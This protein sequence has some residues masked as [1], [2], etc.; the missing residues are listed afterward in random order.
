MSDRNTFEQNPKFKKV[1]TT[2]KDLF[3]RYG[4]KRV[5]IEEICR[6]SG[7]SKMTFYKFF[8]NKL[9]LAKY[10][11]NSIFG[12]AIEE[13]QDI[14]D[15]ENS[16][17]DKLKLLIDLKRRGTDHIGA[18]FIAE[19]S[20]HPEPEIAVIYNKQRERSM[21]ITVIFFKQAQEK[22]ELRS[23]IKL[24]FIIYILNK[25][26]EMSTDDALTGMYTSPQ[27]IALEMTNFLFYGILER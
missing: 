3:Y 13:F 25:M 1:V 16:F 21:D 12:N 11:L 9:E 8:P 5:T 19:L 4:I 6:E 22:G 20:Q 15:S 24:E 26:I 14:V 23:G 2:A 7:V 10:L 27:E 18:E 17:P